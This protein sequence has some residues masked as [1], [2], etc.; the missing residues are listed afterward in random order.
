MSDKSTRNE[1]LVSVIVT[2]YNHSKYVLTCLN[3]IENQAYSNIELIVIDANSSD[4]SIELISDWRNKATIDSKFIKQPKTYGICKNINDG[5][6]IASGKYVQVIAADDYLDQNKFE[7][8]IERFECFEDKGEGVAMMFSRVGK[9]DENGTI[10]EFKDSIVPFDKSISFFDSLLLNNF[11]YAPS[12][13]ITRKHLELIGG[14]DETLQFNDW[15]MWLRLSKQ[16][17]LSFYKEY[18][19]AYYRKIGTSMTYNKPIGFYISTFKLFYKHYN[20]SLKNEF[21]IYQLKRAISNWGYMNGRIAG[22]LTLIFSFLFPSF[23]IFLFNRYIAMK[24]RRD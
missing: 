20:V 24:Y 7:R 18:T 19:S 4:N 21:V 14:Y 13:M 16:F 17:R 3:S 15:D 5:L 11:I 23:S 6:K 8:Y 12:A 1:P 22:R 9:V 10:Y 2:C